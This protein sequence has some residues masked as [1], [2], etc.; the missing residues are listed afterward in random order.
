MRMGVTR[1]STMRMMR[2][3]SEFRFPFSLSLSIDWN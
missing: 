2:M 1:R 3:M